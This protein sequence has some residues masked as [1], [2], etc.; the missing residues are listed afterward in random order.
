MNML[1]EYKEFADEL[2]KLN[3]INSIDN[4][5][6]SMHWRRLERTL[7]SINANNNSDVERILL[8][9]DFRVSLRHVKQWLVGQKKKS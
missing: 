7:R 9:S 5:D 4:S 3:L 6:V 8:E 1:D 2:N